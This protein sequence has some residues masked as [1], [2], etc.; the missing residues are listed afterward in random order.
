MTPTTSV[1]FVTALDRFSVHAMYLG[2]NES[3]RER[4]CVCVSPFA[5]DNL[6]VQ[7]GAMESRCCPPCLPVS[8]LEEGLDEAGEDRSDLV[9]NDVEV[10]VGLDLF[11]LLCHLRRELSGGQ[12]VFVSTMKERRSAT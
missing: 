6:G 10:E 5:L 1:Q 12:N 7:A 3:E 4:E 2:P 8:L 9:E 11:D